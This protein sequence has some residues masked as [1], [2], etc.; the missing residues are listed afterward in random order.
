MSDEKRR[1]PG[2]DLFWEEADL[3]E[4]AEHPLRRELLYRL[5][6]LT[7]YERLIADAHSNGQDQ[8]VACLVAQRRR[9]LS[10]IESLRSALSRQDARAELDGRRNDARTSRPPLSTD[11]DGP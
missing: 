9:E 6:V 5:D 2:L 4:S 10:V 1:S 3:N 7:R 8:Q 11:A